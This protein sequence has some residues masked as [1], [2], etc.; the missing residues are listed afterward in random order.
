VKP[1]QIILLLCWG[2]VTWLG[3]GKT[4]QFITVDNRGTQLNSYEGQRI[5]ILGVPAALQHGDFLPPMPYSEGR[6]RIVINKVSCTETVN[7]ENEP[8]IRSMLQM[9]A[10]A[11]R[12]NRPIKVLGI[13]RG[14]QLDIEY[15]EGIR[16]DTAWHKN[17][18]PY[19]SYAAYYEWYPFAYSPNARVPKISRVR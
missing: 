16:T 8:R 5:S 12:E 4:Y 10:V 6:W 15:F 17:K 2:C 18:N 9:A 14:G 1:V 19:Y 7:F 13:V 11:R 3:C